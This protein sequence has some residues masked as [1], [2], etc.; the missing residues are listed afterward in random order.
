[1]NARRIV[2]AMAVVAVIVS[3]TATTGFAS[4][5]SAS[6]PAF[7]EDDAGRRR[8]APRTA[9]I[10]RAQSEGALTVI[11]LPGDWCSYGS[12]IEDFS[13]TYGITVNSVAP[14][15]SSAEELQAIRDGIGN[16]GSNTP[17]V[18]DVGPGFA[19]QARAEGLI[20][21][22]KVSTWDQI[23]R[24]MKDRQGYWYGDYYGLMAVAANTA[25]T[26]APS[27]WDDLLTNEAVAAAAL[28]GDPT[29]SNMALFSVYA[30]ALGNGGSADDIEPGLWFFRDLNAAGRLSPAIGGGESLLSG[31][32]PVL[33]EWSYL[34]QAQI[35]ANPETDITFEV[36]EPALAGF[37]AQAISAYAPHPNAARLWMEYLYSDEGQLAF[38]EGHCIPVRYDDL[39]AR[40]LIR[41]GLLPD[42]TGAVIPSVDQTA[43]AQLFVE[44]N[45]TCTVYGYG[46]PPN[47][48]TSTAECK[49]DGW[50]DYPHLGFRNQG[51]CVSFVSSGRFVCR[52][53]L[54]CVS[55]AEGDPIRLAS[56]LW[57][58][59][60]GG[61]GVDSRLGVE[62]ALAGQGELF[63]HGFD[64]RSEDDACSEE[65]GG[66]AAEAIA[67][68]TS[69]AAVVGPTCSNAARTAAPILSAAGYSMVSPSS[70]S[71]HLTDPATHEEGFLRTAWNDKDNA[72]AMAEFLV[73]EG[74]ESAV[75]LVESGDFYS[76]TLGQSFAAVFGQQTGVPVGVYEVAWDEDAE[77]HG[78]S[79]NEILDGL[80]GQEPDVLFFPVFEPLG[81]EIVIA[82][83]SRSEFDATLMASNDALYT[84]DFLNRNGAV[85]AGMLFGVPDD[86]F[87]QSAAYAEFREWF[88]EQHGTE[89]FAFFSAHAYDATRMI[90]EAI[91]RTAI[92]DG[93]GTLHIGRQA[94]RSALFATEGM[95]GVTGTIT[96]D[97]YGDCGVGGFRIVEAGPPPLT[98]RVN[99]GH[100]WV[101]S[102]YPSGYTVRVDVF[103]SV[104]SPKGSAQMV[105][106]PKDFW[107][108]GTGF[109]T[110]ESDW[111]EA[112][113][114]IQPGDRVTAEVVGTD[115]I[116]E[117]RLG[118]ITANID[119]EGDS[120]TGT[121]E[122]SWITDPVS[123]EC[124]DWGSGTGAFNKDAGSHLTN[125]EDNFTCTW[126]PE[127]EWDLR[128]GQ[129][130]GVGY[131]GPDGHWV[132]NAFHVTNPT[133]VAYLPGA[134]E[135]YDWPM[136]HTIELGINSNYGTLAVSEQRPD[137]PEG[138]T[139]VLFEVWRDGI[140][141]KDGDQIT[142]IDEATGQRKEL[143]VTNLA[144]TDFD[145]E[146][147]NV[148]GLFDPDYSL[149]VWMYGQDGQEPAMV[150]DTWTATFSELPPGAWGGATQK[151]EDG[152]GTSIDF[153]VPT[154]P[155]ERE[156]IGVFEYTVPFVWEEEAHSYYYRYSYM[157]PE[158]GGEE[159]SPIGFVAES[160]GFSY[161]GF[162][163][164]RPGAVRA[165]VEGG[166]DGGC[167]PVNPPIVDPAQPTR[168]VWGGVT[169]SP[170]T[171]EEAVEHFNS[172][173]A[174]VYWDGASEPSATLGLIE[175]LEW[176]GLD[177]WMSY[178]CSTFA[179]P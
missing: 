150:G 23:P 146:A 11:A 18:I 6:R 55:Y 123:V 166:E 4:G 99:Y 128:A 103:D 2:N 58:S 31:E 95:P 115:I 157:V 137:A 162:V 104:G 48:P 177:P 176:T 24:V 129:D 160:G 124:L 84:E 171:Y 169:P 81:S 3:G 88:L 42:P 155:A 39:N 117:V 38:A 13:S 34:A 53:A 57:L 108:G 8:P 82:V 139:R 17:D 64:L 51:D 87:T 1:M 168:F 22:Y 67:A 5:P 27:S 60:E 85:I 136:G 165:A 75:V 148:I 16:P 101:E 135:G 61:L 144:V 76:T 36:T 68:D 92:V 59:D 56:A 112:V 43:A 63:G 147:G 80:V 45:W 138:E 159:T 21:P 26:A 66:V 70:T 111:G 133:F 140:E 102:F 164:L 143:V 120:V 132:A 49:K 145:L 19:V 119:L 154:P 83:R 32:T 14:G 110:Q 78:T 131:T 142:M 127:T 179:G 116:A 130:I 74:K 71:P 40:G 151:D 12:I 107:G 105:T 30:A 52:D 73:G 96:C 93:R 113:P 10:R 25:F 86:S 118:E 106:E 15:A 9:L 122:A 109:Q 77:S 62:A 72:V 65:G 7:G 46:C 98:L 114:D 89:P 149:W 100:D 141:L 33:L 37:Y 91:E 47:Q 28:G 44:T 156:W 69:I 158:V 94:L 54:G 126:D 134:V 153:Q 20:A 170:M 79:L 167:P 175:I 121:I 97:P 152:D 41:D 178:V 161:D 35:E 90:L 174:H 163:L 173:T 172:A 50:R 125:G 29:A